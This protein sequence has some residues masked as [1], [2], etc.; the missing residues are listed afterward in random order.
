LIVL[1]LVCTRILKKILMQQIH[2]IP[3]TVYAQQSPSQIE[4]DEDSFKAR[5]EKLKDGLSTN[6]YIEG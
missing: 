1:F 5:M 4:H 3:G 2:R 6:L